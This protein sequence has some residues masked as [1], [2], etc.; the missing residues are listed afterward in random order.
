MRLRIYTQLGFAT[1]RPI[2]KETEGNFLPHL[3]T[4][5]S[6]QGHGLI[7]RVFEFFRSRCAYSGCGWNF[8]GDYRGDDNRLLH[9]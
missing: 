4:D 5:W 8:A 3:I 7:T 1:T 9:F 2:Y 6:I